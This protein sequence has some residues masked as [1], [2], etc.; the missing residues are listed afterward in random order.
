MDIT[1][2]KKTFQIYQTFTEKI[3]NEVKH[4]IE[5]VVRAFKVQF[6]NQIDYFKVRIQFLSI[7]N[8]LDKSRCSYKYQRL[9][10]NK[11]GSLNSCEIAPSS[12]DYGPC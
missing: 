3:T 4:G 8:C 1:E 2:T 5:C 9:H 7:L 6:K 12:S 11:G 10:K